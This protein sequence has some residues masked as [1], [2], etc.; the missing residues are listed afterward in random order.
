MRDLN[1]ELKKLIDYANSN[2][3]IRGLILQGSFINEKA[4]ID[5]FSDLDP[6]FY[7][8]DLSEFID[9]D[10]WKN[11][12]GKPISF[13]HD[14]GEIK[15]SLNW[16]TRLTIFDDGFKMDF[17][18][19]S[20]EAAKYAND[21]PL[22]KIYVDKDNIIPIPD[23]LDDSKFFVKKPSE[24]EFVNILNE[25]FFDTSYVVKS[26]ARNEM[27]FEKYMEHILQDKIYMLLQWYIGCKN[28]FQV[29]T[30][31]RGRYFRKYLNDEEWELLL[32]TY[33]NGNINECSKSLFSAFKLVNYLGNYIADY[34]GYEYPLE[35]EQNMYDYCVDKINRYL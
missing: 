13:F 31:T 21:M 9:N 27:F 32:E 23:T 22:Y 19:A 11:H 28:N 1:I 34:L 29:N 26:L 10:E 8:E 3:N 2:D 30:G 20:V 12:F 18:F 35:H 33:S 4:F 24:K 25:F 6:L 16:Y 5:D 15:D 17:G 14:Q 7:V